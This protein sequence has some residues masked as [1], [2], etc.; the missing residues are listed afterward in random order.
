MPIAAT[1]LRQVMSKSIQRAIREHVVP[2]RYTK[3]P[4][5]LRMSPVVRRA[6]VGLHS[7]SQRSANKFAKA[8]EESYTPEKL[9]SNRKRRSIE[10]RSGSMLE[11]VYETAKAADIADDCENQNETNDQIES[12]SKEKTIG[13]SESNTAGE[14]A[15][16]PMAVTPVGGSTIH[17]NNRNDKT[18][19]H[20]NVVDVW[21]TPCENIPIK[22]DE[23]PEV[24]E[25]YLYQVNRCH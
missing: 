12:S 17:A 10:L 20:E 19:D 22:R 24:I 6:G 15:N 7:P 14:I 11:T 13:T 3:S 2:D 5:D 21:Y 1:P 16:L 9:P 4:L 25:P 18:D 8:I 23:H